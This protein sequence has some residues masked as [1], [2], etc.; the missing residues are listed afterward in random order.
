M[1]PNPEERHSKDQNSIILLAQKQDRYLNKA[2][3][4]GQSPYRLLS[5]TRLPKGAV[6][7]DSTNWGSN[8]PSIHRG[9]TL[10][11]MD[12]KTYR[13][14]EPRIREPFHYKWDNDIASIYATEYERKR[15]R[16]P[17]DPCR[18][19]N[20][21]SSSNEKQKGKLIQMDSIYGK[22][23][24]DYILEK[25]MKELKYDEWVPLHSLPK[26]LQN[27]LLAQTSKVEHQEM[28][29]S[30][31]ATTN[32]RD[33]NQEKRSWWSKL[34][35]S[36]K[37]GVSNPAI[38]DPSPD[39]ANKIYLEPSSLINHKQDVL[40]ENQP[41]LRKRKVPPPYVPPPS[42]DYPHRFFPVKKE[43]VH[44]S[45]RTT[46]KPSAQILPL[47]DN[48]DCHESR[49]KVPRYSV[50]STR[51][52]KAN[53]SSSTNIQEN[54]MEEDK[55]KTSDQDLQ[56][57][58]QGRKLP[59]AHSAWT[60]PNSDEFLDHIYECVE[61]TSSPLTHKTPNF[62]KPKSDLD[63]Q[64]GKMIYGTVS[65]PLQRDTSMPYTKYASDKAICDEIEA[66]K[67][68]N[69]IIE[70][71]QR[72]MPPFDVRP[73][74]P[75][76]GV[77][78]P[79]E[80]GFSYA[81]GDFQ[82]PD[83]RI[84]RDYI[85]IIKHDSEQ[86]HEWRRP[87]RVISSK[88]SKTRGHSKSSTN[89]VEY[90]RYSHTLPLKKQYMKPHMQEELKHGDSRKQRVSYHDTEFPRWRET[91]NI[92]TLP[93]RS[94][95]H[96][97]WR[98]PDGLKISKKSSSY[99][100]HRDGGRSQAE[101][102]QPVL[103]DEN[104]GLFVIDAT[105]VVVKAEYIFPP[106][107]E[108]VK[109]V[110]DEK[111]KGETLAV[112]D[113]SESLIRK[114]KAPHSSSHSKPRSRLAQQ[115]IPQKSHPKA[116]HCSQMSPQ[117]ESSTLK[118]RAV[119]ILGL[120]IGELEYLNDARDQHQPNGSLTTIIKTDQGHKMNKQ[121]P[122]VLTHN[123]YNKKE[124]KIRNYKEMPCIL[125]D[126]DS[127]PAVL[128]ADNDSGLPPKSPMCDN[129]TKE[130]KGLGSEQNLLILDVQNTN[131]SE[132][133]NI[134]VQNVQILATPN[135]LECPES[136]NC[137]GIN[138][139]PNV[140]SDGMEL[141][142]TMNEHPQEDVETI[143]TGQNCEPSP[144]PLDTQLPEKLR[145]CKGQLFE[146]VEEECHDKHNKISTVTEKNTSEENPTILMNEDHCKPT[147]HIPDITKPQV[148]VVPD[149][150]GR[151]RNSD[152]CLDQ[153]DGTSSSRSMMKAY[154]RRPN[155]Y[156]KDLREAVSRI[157]RHTAPDSDTDED[158]ERPSSDSVEQVSEECVTSCSSDTSD[159]EVTVILCEDTSPITEDTASEGMS[160]HSEDVFSEDSMVAETSPTTLQKGEFGDQSKIFPVLELEASYDLNTCIEEILQDLHKTEQEFFS[161]CED[162][163]KGPADSGVMDLLTGNKLLNTVLDM[164]SS[165]AE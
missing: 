89:R 30:K 116:Q 112:R 126:V 54:R 153:T 13:Q 123:G 158:L 83:K 15:Q 59:R 145:Q 74:I 19:I 60:G 94:R 118:E 103:S 150:G 132:P 68:K 91:G 131:S 49:E 151:Q 149:V 124:S 43:K 143:V 20:H 128:E 58:I 35:K 27:Q 139:Y 6:L 66:A 147:K 125:E 29:K 3:M 78:L 93:G 7:Q 36:A 37:S 82:N 10:G 75:L 161:S 12:K 53:V 114:E 39:K 121:E 26:A 88:E 1:S 21:S 16:L 8:M 28:E 122:E 38:A 90:G 18:E 162:Q 119:R 67:R 25:K 2:P 107:M 52:A 17:G 55:K 113:F 136:E 109:F 41:Q 4:R 120:S 163:S 115:P 157:R 130:I 108:Q 46:Q 50:E 144:D 92:N 148:C 62:L 33:T 142:P 165:T 51:A 81:S 76:H 5:T 160:G 137:I 9:S 57:M 34:V 106:V 32:S 96:N 129:G 100:R 110:P 99:E 140:V 134:S 87:L 65:F 73:P 64:T 152:I 72:L 63:L 97:R 102:I 70:N 44:H 23:E 133:S 47:H 146:L 45:G 71:S 42:Y 154:S 48:E 69:K 111:P 141:V 85:N 22:W 79:R 105:C 127:I 101:E 80:L 155:Y 98:Y 117:R 104:E 164:E 61:G 31:S 138:A 40:K 135:P 159:S 56:S 24:A 11:G 14:S 156:A 84:Q 95:D 86:G 77:K